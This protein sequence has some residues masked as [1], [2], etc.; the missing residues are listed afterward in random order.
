MPERRTLFPVPVTEEIKVSIIG[1][2]SLSRLQKELCTSGTM[3]TFS[4]SSRRTLRRSFPLCLGACTGSLKNTGTRE[5]LLVQAV[6]LTSLLN[7]FDFMVSTHKLRRGVATDLTLFTHLNQKSRF[8][9]HN[10]APAAF[11]TE[12]KPFIY[13]KKI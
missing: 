6:C 11:H 12:L 3:S 4:A 5:Y 8:V 13:L 9:T 2:T 7:G 1:W 10:S